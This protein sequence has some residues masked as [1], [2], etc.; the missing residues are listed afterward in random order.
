[1]TVGQHLWI[2]SRW[3]GVGGWAASWTTTA[4]VGTSHDTWYYRTPGGDLHSDFGVRQADLH[5]VVY[6]TSPVPAGT[7]TWG[8]IKAIYR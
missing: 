1:M 3:E 5:L 2:S 6:G 7:A 4:T 8:A